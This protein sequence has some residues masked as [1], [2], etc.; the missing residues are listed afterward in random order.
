MKTE[1]ILILSGLVVL[2]YFIYKESTKPKVK[3]EVPKN[4]TEEKP[5]TIFLDLTQDAR[6][7]TR[8]QT[9]QAF[10]QDYVKDYNASKFAT[11][12]PPMVK[13]QT[14]YNDL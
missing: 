9:R 10:L 2:G 3:V 7:M 5:Q 6:R 8:Q 14:M 11:V 4:T 12:A 1:N 13:V